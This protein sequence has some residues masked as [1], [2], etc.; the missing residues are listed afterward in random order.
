[1]NSAP[2]LSEELPSAWPDAVS[3]YLR[4]KYGVPALVEPL[5]G[6]SGGSVWRVHVPNRTL[7]VKRPAHHREVFFYETVAPRLRARGVNLP[8]LEWSA[9]FPDSSWVLTEDIAK[10]LP[11]FRWLADRQALA[12]LH[13]L[14]ETLI[15]DAAGLPEY[16]RP[17]WSDAMTEK[18]LSFLPTSAAKT[19]DTLLHRVQEASQPLFNPSGLI[20]GDPNPAN[21][22]M[23]E[24][25]T[26]VLYDWE[27]C[28]LGK[29][30]LDLGITIP[31]LGNQGTFDLVAQTYLQKGAARAIRALSEEIAIA[32]VR[33]VV[34]FMAEFVDGVAQIQPAHIDQ[35]GKEFQAWLADEIGSV[36]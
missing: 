9:H 14:H 19:L 10:P 29:P 17:Q 7:V 1:M 15:E 22:G 30:A 34:E 35:L 12:M 11:R 6:M 26:L 18:A 28:G 32:K 2:A 27:R 36:F 21:W 16:F 23:R 5:N 3:G 13:T 4:S 20:S 25:G 8:E 31:W 24:D 33:S